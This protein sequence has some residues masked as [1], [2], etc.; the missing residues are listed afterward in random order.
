MH[1]WVE[2]DSKAINYNLAQFKKKI[3]PDKLLMPVVKAN[4]Y[5]H[6]IVEI[7]KICDSNRGVNRICVVNDDEA[8]LLVKSNIKKP[9]MILKKRI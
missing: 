2:V 9:I 5:G 4:A 1:T 3:G 7:A 6:G 8:F